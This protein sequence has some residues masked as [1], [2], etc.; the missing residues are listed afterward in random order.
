ME[1]RS[2]DRKIFTI[3]H[4]KNR[5][6]QIRYENYL[7]IRAEII[8]NEFQ[9]YE[10]KPK[11]AFGTSLSVIDTVN[12]NEV[13]QLAMTWNGEIHISFRNLQEYIIKLNNFFSNQYF[14]EN[15]QGEKLILLKSKFNW[16]QFQY[17]YDIE[18]NV[19]RFDTSE[20]KLLL[21][22]GI[23]AVNYYIITLSGSNAGL[24]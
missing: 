6:G 12:N 10:I 11:G 2:T 19:D 21:L 7:Y 1:A 22:L 17:H 23:Y 3:T 8:I 20:N 4:K 13:A 24:T 15:S 18:Y 9:K 14:L 16:V 5:I